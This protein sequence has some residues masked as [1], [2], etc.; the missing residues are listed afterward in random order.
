[1]GQGEVVNVEV[2][3]CR[4]CPGHARRFHSLPGSFKGVHRGKVSREVIGTGTEAQ[5]V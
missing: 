5:Y 4:A 3:F 1:M 2:A